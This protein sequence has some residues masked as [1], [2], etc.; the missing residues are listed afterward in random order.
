MATSSGSGSSNNA[1]VYLRV[2]TEEQVE[3]YSLDTQA[4]ICQKEAERRGLGL[5]KVFREEG[6]SAK[7]IQGRP[8][9]IELLEYGNCLPP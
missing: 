2:S 4:E 6:R 9:L 5:I 3:N 8:T 1:V 7:N